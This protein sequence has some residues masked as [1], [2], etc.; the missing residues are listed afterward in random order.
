M[1]QELIKTLLQLRG[2]IPLAAIATI[3]RVW[4]S[5]PRQPGAKMLVLPDGRTFGT[6]GGGCGEAEV[7]RAAL[8]VMDSRQPRLYHL[9]LTA[10]LAE[11]EGMVCGGN[12]E[13][14]IDPVIIPND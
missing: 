7:R 4:G 3:T 8:E 2:K 11:E 6:I 9:D 13:V 14:F 1:E 10:D 5:T 12:M